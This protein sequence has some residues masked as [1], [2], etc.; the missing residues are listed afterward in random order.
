[1][2]DCLF[3]KIINKE[4]PTEFIYEDDLV[5]AFL[6][7]HPNNP[8]HFLVMP[9]NH[10]VDLLASS[11]VD[12]DGCMEAIKKIGSKLQQAFGT[13]AFNIVQNNGTDAGQII[14]HLHFHVIP[15]YPDDL[16]RI[17]PPE[18]NHEETIAEFREKIKKALS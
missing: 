7:I 3:C 15:R 4:I 13:N 12:V 18:H 9:K 14:M 17:Y 5:V 1:M 16:L 11:A 10:A 6:D 2:S 8:G